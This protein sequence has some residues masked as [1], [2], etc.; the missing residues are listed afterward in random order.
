[1]KWILQEDFPI[2]ADIINPVRKLHDHREKYLEV[3]SSSSEETFYIGERIAALLTS[4][5]VVALNGRLGCGK[6]T[7]AKGI[8]AG[9]GIIDNLTSPTYTI[10]NEYPGS[11]YL[12]HIDAYRLNDSRDFEDI[13]GNEII[14]SPGICIIEWS[15]RISKSLPRNIITISMKITGLFSRLL[16]I[17]GIE[18]L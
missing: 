17:K 13:G 14:N 5:S 7:L 4:G 1:M 2:N 18:T 9:L 3:D 6:T 11:P 15:E 12:Y 8:A 10:I 16:Q